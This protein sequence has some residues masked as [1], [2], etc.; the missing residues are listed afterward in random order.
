MRA[1]RK[2]LYRTQNSD[3]AVLDCGPRT[4]DCGLRNFIGPAP[5][6]HPIRGGASRSAFWIR[7]TALRPPTSVSAFFIGL[8]FASVGVSAA[9]FHPHSSLMRPSGSL[10]DLRAMGGGR[11]IPHFGVQCSMFSVRCSLV[12]LS[13][14]NIPRLRSLGKSLSHKLGMVGY[15]P[16]TLNDSPQ[17]LYHAPHRS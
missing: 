13:A 14:P 11:L 3:R 7:A 8:E 12:Q 4:V 5:L 6:F 16:I 2:E 17:T 9:V 10:S 15:H 1:M